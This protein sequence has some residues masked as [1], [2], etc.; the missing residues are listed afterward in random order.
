[1]TIC[2][3][4]VSSK[5]KNNGKLCK[6][7][8]SFFVTEKKKNSVSLFYLLF[9]LLNWNL[10]LFDEIFVC[11]FLCFLKVSRMDEEMINWGSFL[12]FFLN[13]LSSISRQEF[14]NKIKKMK[15]ENFNNFSI[16][17]LSCPENF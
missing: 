4:F 15:K 8:P 12:D 17:T 7:F 2:L 11:F 6:H 9:G 10:D 1:M 14:P 5:I 3:D 16:K 13:F